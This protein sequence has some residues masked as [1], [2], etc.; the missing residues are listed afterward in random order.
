MGPFDP[1]NGEFACGAREA[2]ADREPSL[3]P[4]SAQEI[5][6]PDV[7][8]ERGVAHEGQLTTAWLAD[9]GSQTETAVGSVQ[10]SSVG[11]VGQRVFQEGP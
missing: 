11:E 10:S 6:V 3:G 4:R 5:E 9:A 2:K 1:R 8:L 7:C